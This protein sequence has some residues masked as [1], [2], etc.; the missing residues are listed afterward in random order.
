V[1]RVQSLLKKLDAENFQ[2]REAASKALAA[3]DQPAALA[4]RRMDRAGWSEE[5]V[6]RVD[7]FL[8]K[9]KPT[10]DVDAKR[11]R[12]DRDFLLDC[13]FSDDAQIRQLAFNELQQVV[14]RPIEFNLTAPPQQRLESIQRLRASIGATPTTHAK[15]R[16]E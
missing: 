14:G 11:L 16:A 5:Q 10:N 15:S 2:D 8:A 1:A 13:L 9:Y 12:R 7:A 4:L 3:L 6:G